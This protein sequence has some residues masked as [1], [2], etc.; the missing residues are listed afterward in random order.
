MRIGILSSICNPKSGAR[1]PLELAINLSR[2][3]DVTFYCFEDEKDPSSVKRMHSEGV[4]ISFIPHPKIPILGNTIAFFILFFRLRGSNLQVINAHTTL[5]L[6]LAAKASGIPLVGSY[7]GT[8]FNVLDERFLET[9][10]FIKLINYFLNFLFFIKG[11]MLVWLPDKTIA[12]SSYAAKESE[13]IYKKKCSFI[14]IG[15]ISNPLARYSSIEKKSNSVINLL[16]VSRIT[17]YKQF[18]LIVNSVKNL[19]LKKIK[20]NLTIVG[21]SPQKE[22][23]SLLNKIKNNRTKILLGPSDKVLSNLYKSSDIYLSADKYLFFGMP[24]LEAASFGK[25]AVAL[26]CAAASEVV[27]HGKTGYLANSK[28]EFENYLDKLITNSLLRL[29][30]G[31][32]AKNFSKK[33]SWENTISD[34]TKVFNNL[35]LEKRTSFFLPV[36]GLTILGTFLRI[37]FIDKHSFWFDE[38][39]SYF[40]SKR[41]IL[42]L[43]RATAADNHP[44][45]YFLLL[46]L[47][48]NISESVSSLRFLSLLFGTATIPLFYFVGKKLTS[49]RVAFLATVILAISPL[50]IYFSTETRV[51]SLLVFE[52]LLCYF[53]LLKY[54]QKPGKLYLVLITIVEIIALHSHYYF[55]F[56]I[57]SI[58]LIFFIS[59]VRKSL[60][61]KSWIFSQAVV[62][63]SLIPWIILVLKA[64]NNNCWCF[65]TWVGLP[66]MFAAFTVSGVGILSLKDY[67]LRGPPI[68]LPVFF[69]TS[70]LMLVFFLLG[71]FRARSKSYLFQSFYFPLI[72]L[73]IISL[74]ISNFSP[75]SIILLSPFYFLGISEGL[76]SLKSKRK[77]YIWLIL[78]LLT[79]VLL[80]QYFVSFYHN[81]SLRDGANLISKNFKQDE[82]I[83][84]SSPMTF[85]SYKYYHSSKYPEFLVIPSDTAYYTIAE[86]GGFDKPIEKIVPGYKNVWFVNMPSW[87]TPKEIS[88]IE[89]YLSKDYLRSEVVRYNNLEIYHY[90]HR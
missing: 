83:I 2:I 71:T 6:L 54:L 26:N 73:S 70:V 49:S 47:W 29:K 74:F 50:H 35:L 37:I 42:S 67:I 57:F 64:P 13:R 20:I 66:T 9:N 44:P 24:I 23:L 82:V 4:K 86:I 40:V 19:D 81:S 30:F 43:F 46:K 36:V 58:N 63:I 3:H 27:T 48:M 34:Y 89:K 31:K 85:Y 15:A 56:I 22:Y 62:L 38:A 60:E 72:I 76:Y 10:L 21:S 79:V 88:D 90:S 28:E 5:S 52:T 51:Y 1:A 32:N 59:S 68:Y 78:S 17:P 53:L 14:Y 18:D 39:E 41:P 25:P 84:H 33:F 69:L 77:F 75:R 8:Q 87:V 12:I 7:F 80:I 16:S 61:F 11:L 65:Y 45:F 55:I